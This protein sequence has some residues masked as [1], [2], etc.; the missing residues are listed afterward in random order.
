MEVKNLNGEKGKVLTIEGEK[1]KVI[2]PL[3]KGCE[4]CGLC[5]R[6]ADNLME[7]ELYFKGDL[8]PGSNVKIYV[9]PRIV[10][11]SSFMLYILPLIFLVAGYYVG[12]LFDIHFLLKSKGELF[13]AV[14]SFLFFFF[15]FIPIHIVDKI[16]RKDENFR[17]FAV[18]DD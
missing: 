5:R 12:K 13:P 1:V 10:I 7:M 14:F 3:S 4:K 8:K 2:L 9:S 15:S 17:I 11:F 6:I 18:P 16:K